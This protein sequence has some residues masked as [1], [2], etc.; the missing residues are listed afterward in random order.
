M[1]RLSQLPTALVLIVF[2]VPIV[3]LVAAS[4]PAA[5]VTHAAGDGPDAATGTYQ[6]HPSCAGVSQATPSNPTCDALIASRPAPHVSPL[7]V[8]FGV[9]DDVTFIRFTTSDV[10]LYDEPNGTPVSV[11]GAGYTYMAVRQVHDGFAEVR[12][13]RWVDLAIARYARPSSFTGVQIHGLDMPFAWVLW[14]HCAANAP[15]GTRSCDGTGQLER[16]QLVNIYATVNVSGWDWHLIGPGLW[17]NQQN[18]SIVYPSAPAQFG[19]DW[20]AVNT[21][22]QNVVAYRGAV[23][24]MATLVSTGIE[25]GEW[26]T[27][28]GTYQVRLMM[29]NGPMDGGAEEDFYSLDQVPYH[30]YFNGLVALHGAYWHESWGYTHSHGC[31]NMAISDAHWLYHNWVQ[32]GTTVYVYGEN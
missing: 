14:P 6:G 21:Y 28:I 10:P 16:F 18:L 31:V 7:P 26:D 32:E 4:G 8:D 27:K 13:N 15:A 19:G 24:M 5:P 25:N 3:L 11:L 2:T 17:T 20:V 30:M 1:Q 9:I 23:P 22:E 29:E 12:P